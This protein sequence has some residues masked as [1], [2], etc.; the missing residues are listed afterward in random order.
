MN[1]I[2]NPFPE[3]IEDESSGV[4][5]KSQRYED[6]ANGYAAGFLANLGRT[7]GA[8]DLIAGAALRELLR[9]V[10]PR[11]LVKLEHLGLAPGVKKNTV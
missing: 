1:F 6:W 7:P 11:W 8:G 4:K 10:S 9:Q 3:Y 2:Q 5:V